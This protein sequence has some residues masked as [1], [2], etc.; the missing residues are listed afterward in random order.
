M[1]AKDGH[2][3]NRKFHQSQ[4]TS[5]DESDAETAVSLDLSGFEK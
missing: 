3:Q 5:H 1:S 4:T 2:R